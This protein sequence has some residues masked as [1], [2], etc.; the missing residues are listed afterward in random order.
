MAEPEQGQVRIPINNPFAVWFAPPF[1]PD[2]EVIE[3]DISETDLINAGW[4]KK[5]ET[6]GQ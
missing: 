6:D 5:D 4:V 3:I 2:S 1:G